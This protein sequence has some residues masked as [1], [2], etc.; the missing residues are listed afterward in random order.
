M[1]KAMVDLSEFENRVL[2][3]VK[4]KYGLG[5]KSEAVRLIIQAYESEFLE[6]ELKPEFIEKMQKRQK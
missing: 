4:A 6:P 2:N 1:V 5:N 3:I